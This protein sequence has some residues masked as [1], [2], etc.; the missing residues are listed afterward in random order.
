[1]NVVAAAEGLSAQQASS[2]FVKQAVR[3]H[4]KADPE[5]GFPGGWFGGVVNKV[6]RD[7]ADPVTGEVFDG[8]LFL[9]K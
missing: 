3:K 4:F 5:S 6:D 7:L 1:M 8:L 9:I 2:V